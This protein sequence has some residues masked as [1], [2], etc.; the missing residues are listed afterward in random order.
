M[1]DLR[2]VKKISAGVMEALVGKEIWDPNPCPSGLAVE[3]SGSGAG[4]KVI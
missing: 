1:C 3:R 2:E 4:Q